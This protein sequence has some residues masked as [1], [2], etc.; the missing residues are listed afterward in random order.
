MA[1]KKKRSFIDKKHSSTYNLVHRSQRDIVEDLLENDVAKSTMILWPASDHNNPITDAALLLQH[2]DDNRG[3][4]AE[5][6][7]KL[8]QANLLDDS[9]A[10]LKEI[11]GSGVFIGGGDNVGSVLEARNHVVTR[12]F[13]PDDAL[14]EVP[15]YDAI[16]MSTDCMDEDIAAILYDDFE[17]GDYEELNDDFVLCAAQEP[18]TD[19]KDEFD[20]DAHI[21]KL[22]EQGKERVIDEKHSDHLFFSKLKP[23]R[24]D[25]EDSLEQSSSYDD[26]PG[27]VSTLSPEEER[28]LCEKFEET[29]LEYDSDEV[30]DCPDDEIAGPVPLEDEGLNAALDDFL[31]EKSDDVFIHGTAAHDA[32]KKTGGSSFTVLIGTRMVPATLLDV[33]T[34]KTSVETVHQ[35]LAMADDIL[36]QPYQPPPAEEVLIDGVSYFS[37]RKRNPWDCES[38]LSTYSNLDNNPV[39]IAARST[40]RR[41]RG[42]GQIPTQEAHEVIQLSNKTGLPIPSRDDD[43]GDDTVVSVNRGE[44]RNKDETPEERRLRKT[45]LK[46]ERQMARIQKKVTREVFRDEFQKRAIDVGADDI[47]GTTVFRYS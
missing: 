7:N 6:R 8:A 15:K 29:L 40:R 4:I 34:H 13:Q 10:Y 44:G 28:A 35:T 36:R 17:E 24:A 2:D 21:Q 41:G 30:G 46:K 12:P 5:W 22:L 33:G 37:E 9:N 39:T 25:G 45:A 23:L 16:P 19:A 43:V 27:I 20:W 42:Q 3:W 26:A 14:I 31:L 38:I 1:R 11:T 32:I 18:A 47:A